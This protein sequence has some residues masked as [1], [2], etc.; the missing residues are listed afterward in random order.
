MAGRADDGRVHHQVAAPARSD[1]AGEHQL[2][3]G[4]ELAALRDARSRWRRAPPATRAACRAGAGRSRSRSSRSRRGRR[5]HRRARA[6]APPR[7]SPRRGRARP[8]TPSAARHARVETGYAVATRSPSRSAS[9][10]CGASSWHRRLERAAREAELRERV[11]VAP[12]ASATRFAPVIPR[13][14]TPSWTYSGMSCA[15][16]SSRSTG[17]FAH[18]TSERALGRLEARARRR[19]TASR[20]GS[21]I[22][23]FEGTAS[24]SRP[25]IS[26]LP[27]RVRSSAIR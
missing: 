2:E 25:S 9:A 1:D 23:P 4:D 12:S 15:R 24:V 10:S 17:A 11:D 14:T 13:W 7:P 6:A 19:R 3:P 8:R 21:A 18:G 26:P 27:R 22:R 20:A 16:T 5:S